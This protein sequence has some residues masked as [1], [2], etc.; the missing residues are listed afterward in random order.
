[1]YTIYKYFDYVYVYHALMKKYTA[2][3]AVTTT[4]FKARHRS[5]PCIAEITGKLNSQG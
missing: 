1:M 3:I 4:S 2:W 5:C